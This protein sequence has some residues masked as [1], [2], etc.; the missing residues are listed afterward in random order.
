M[1]FPGHRDLTVLEAV[2]EDRQITQRT[3]ATRL[4]VALGLANLYV[5]RLVRKGYIKCVN[6][7]PNR[8]HYYITPKGIAEKWRLTYEFMEHS[9]ELY[10]QTRQHLRVVLD[11]RLTDG[12]HRVAIYGTGEPAELAYVSL[13]EL[14][15]DP[16]AVFAHD[17]DGQ[18][19]G[20]AVRPVAEHAAVSYDLMIVAS[21][22]LPGPLVGRL[23]RAGV[24]EDKLCTLRPP[25]GRADPRSG[26]KASLT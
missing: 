2:T 12:C 26:T 21:L 13:R 20:I 17:A 22:E 3:L 16:V 4:G 15:L 10:R 11:A 24:P 14:G 7:R 8:I 9:L 18:F 25:A 1:V 6:V 5:R 19:L 23:V